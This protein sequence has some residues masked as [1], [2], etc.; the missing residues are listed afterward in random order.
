MSTYIDIFENNEDILKAY[1][2][3]SDALDG[4]T[5][6]L[7][8]YSYEAYSGYSFVLYEKD[9]K[10]WE[11]NGS[12]CSCHGLEGQWDPERASWKA[13]STRLLDNCEAQAQLQALVRAHL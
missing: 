2:A 11:V 10:L 13:L 3:P 9:G 6:L 5:V 4:A 1:D 12:H 7:A 8:W